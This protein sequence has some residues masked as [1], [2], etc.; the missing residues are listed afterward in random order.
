MTIRLLFSV[1]I[2]TAPL[3]V[4]T[5]ETPSV[6]EAPAP[7]QQPPSENARDP[8]P[9]EPLS[10]FTLA[11]VSDGQATYPERD[12]RDPLLSDG[13][14]WQPHGHLSFT[15]QQQYLALR[16]SRSLHDSWVLW[17]D[18]AFELPQGFYLGAWSYM[19]LDDNDLSSNSADE[20]DP[21]VGWKG[22]LLGLDFRLES[23]YFNLHPI[24][25]WYEGD[26][27]AQSSAIAKKFDLPWSGHSLRLEAQLDWL[28][29]ADDFEN[30]A[31]ILLPNITH[32]WEHPFGVQTLKFQHKAWLVWDDGFDGPKNSSDG[33]FLRYDAGLYWELKSDEVVL[34]FPGF[35]GLLALTDPH[36][37]RENEASLNFGL[38]FSF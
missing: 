19:G 30:G 35:T 28:S 38:K 21:Y 36:D 16:I 31:L 4:L 22:S 9:S 33:L 23:I 34:M 13:P 2:L 3:T 17:T 10:P 5:Q 24:E 6:P 8:A 14:R 15:L 26:A 11:S 7:P 18:A 27:W 1:L 25:T 20:L 37:G 12:W 32:A 29:K